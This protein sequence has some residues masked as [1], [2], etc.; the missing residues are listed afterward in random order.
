MAD[1]PIKYSDLV[2]DDGAIDKLIQKIQLLE[3]TFLK[4]QKTFQK[5][6]AKTKKATEESSDATED[7]E[8]E[9]EK[10]EKQLEKLLKAN[11]ELSTAEGQMNA[12]KKS[13]VKLVKQEQALKKKL[14]DLTGDQALANEELKVEIS[15][16]QKVIKAQAKANK[17]LTGEYEIQSK[18]LNDLRKQ[19]KNLAVAGKQNST[20]AKKL[21]LNVVELDAK[22]KDIDK[23]VGQTQR[24]VGDY[25]DAVRGA[26]VDT[27]LFSGSMAGAIDESGA[28]GEVI[29][30]LQAIMGV[31]T[32]I[33]QKN[34]VATEVNAMATE[35]ETVSKEALTTSLVVNKKATMSETGALVKNTTATSLATK[36][37]KTFSKALAFTSKAFGKLKVAMVKSGIGLII[38]SLATIIAGLTES[39]AGV[40][41]LSKNMAG[42]GLAIKV[43]FGRIALFGKGVIDVFQ[44]IVKG[45]DALN[46]ASK[47]NFDGAK[48]S[49]TEAGEQFGQAGDSFSKAGDGFIEA[50]QK[51]FDSGKKYSVLT[52]QLEKDTS[53]LRVEIAKLNAEA[54]IQEEIEADATKS[55]KERRIAI[56]KAIVLQQKAS[57][58]NENIVKRELEAE[59][60]KLNAFS[61]GTES[62][63]V[64]QQIV[65]EKAI[66]FIE[67]ETEADIKSQALARNRNM[68]DQDER[69]KDLD[70]IL[71]GFD[72]QKTINEQLIASDKKRFDERRTL[73]N[74]TIE[75]QKKRFGGLN[76]PKF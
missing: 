2:I 76:Y 51:A 26:L 27:D 19:Y 62:R 59:E 30:K 15:Q 63:R 41:G 14:I 23:T 74:E 38:V 43:I 6:I 7:Q 18:R 5:A 8:K 47:F 21:L 53:G 9:L 1:Q 20:E 48:K 12:Q 16:Q 69:E 4:S 67:A 73:L 22:L 46:K 3:T 50:V 13:A 37:Q 52:R 39:S 42:F 40:E 61:K 35:L 66:E 33:T 11:E 29:A 34:T 49:F 68:L 17:G 25:R 28:M 36:V 24:S 32:K 44:G 64:Q 56:E 60:L 70:I 31:L 75:F 55:F 72:N 58:I 45:M 65:N 57:K 54:E 10:L 71:D